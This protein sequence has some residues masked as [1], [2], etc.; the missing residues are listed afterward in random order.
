MN[1]KILTIIL[2]VLLIG[3]FFLPMGAGGNTSAFDLVQGPSFGKNI[4]AILMKYLW[5]VMPLTGIILL[6]GALNNENYFLGR[7]FWALLPLI[8]LLFLLFG[9]P[10]MQGAEIGDIFKTVFKMYGIGVW[11]ALG[12]SLVLAV[13]WPKK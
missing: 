2:S 3:S 13:Y 8:A 4:E 9:I 6:I 10:L 12:A 11:V 1:R 7:G 5:L